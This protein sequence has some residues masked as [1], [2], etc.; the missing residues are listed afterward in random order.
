VDVEPRT[1]HVVVTFIEPLQSNRQALGYDV[2]SQ[3]A[4]KHALDRAYSL[5]SEVATRPIRLLQEKASQ[6]GVI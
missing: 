2:Y 6:A 5:R 1:K 3:A 4:R